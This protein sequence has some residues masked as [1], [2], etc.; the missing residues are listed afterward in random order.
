M[1]LKLKWM[2]I[3]DALDLCCFFKAVILIFVF[4]SIVLLPLAFILNFHSHGFIGFAGDVT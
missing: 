3:Y 4:S 1:L 2:K